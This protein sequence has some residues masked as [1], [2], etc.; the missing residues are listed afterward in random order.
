MTGTER[1]HG[2]APQLAWGI[3]L[4]M[5]TRLSLRYSG[6]AVDAGLMDVYAASANM[7]AFSE[8]MVAAVKAA[9]G[10]SA[11]ARAEVAGFGRG[12]FITDLVFNV[13]GPAATMFSAFSPEHLLNLVKEAF[14]LWKH[15]KGS[16][17]AAINQSGD[18][19]VAVTN[20]NGQI[21]QVK[22][23]TLNL[24]F[25]EK[26][27]ESVGRFVREA[28]EQDGISSVELGSAGKTVASVDEGDA[29]F[30][31][32]VAK[33]APVSENTVNMALILVAP[34]FQDGNKWRFSDGGATFP[35]AILDEEF[36]SRVN[37]GERFGKGDVLQ[38]ELKIIQSRTGSKISVDRQVLKVIEHRISGQQQPL[39]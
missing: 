5:E 17:P 28:L 25:S 15:L 31:V 19:N 34:V 9:Y 4:T 12:S 27:A 36:L 8:F 33:E 37:N 16:P 29:A 10:D 23:D 2:G 14:A 3:I 32:P 20:N 7:I 39:L 30:F 24:V 13:G 22:T 21:I 38:V 1:C 35:A 11:E 6:Q 18:N 26:G